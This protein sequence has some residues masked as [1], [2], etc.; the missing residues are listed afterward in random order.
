MDLCIATGADTDAVVAL[1]DEAVA[2]LVA[3]GRS[4]QWGVAPFSSRS[5]VVALI[6]ARAES[7]TMWVARS[8]SQI[9]GAVVLGSHPPHYIAH[10]AERPEIYISGMIA[11]RAPN[12]RGI[13]RVLLEHATET[14]RRASIGLLRL[15]CY[16]GGDGGLVAYYESAGFRQV[17]RFTVGL[18][19]SRYSGCLLEQRLTTI[20][21]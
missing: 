5:D 17:D 8:Q 9:L 4:D 7:G 12:A 18:M 13:G 2:W 11:S 10:P 6:R 19:G 1:Y 20:V 3:R 16:A 14:A 15:D 21:G